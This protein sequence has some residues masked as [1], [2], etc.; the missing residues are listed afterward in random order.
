MNDS[1]RHRRPVAG[2]WG[3]SGKAL[4]TAVNNL[5]RKVDWEGLGTWLNNTL[6]GVLDFGIAFFEGFDAVGFAN[7]VGR[8]LAKVDWDAISEKLCE[9]RLQAGSQ[10][11]CRL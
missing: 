3:D 7:D 9:I 1:R 5:F 2:Q 11:T 8:A 4:S 6:L 10:H